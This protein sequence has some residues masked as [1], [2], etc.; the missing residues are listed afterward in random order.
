MHQSHLTTPNATYILFGTYQNN[1]IM[2]VMSI[3]YLYIS[4]L[5]DGMLQVIPISSIL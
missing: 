5:Y 4:V 3:K 1:T 2:W